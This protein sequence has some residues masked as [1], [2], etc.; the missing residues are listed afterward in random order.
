MRA[1]AATAH[2]LAMQQPVT[3][4]IDGGKTTIASAPASGLIVSSQRTFPRALPPVCMAAVAD[5]T[6][7]QVRHLLKR[8][9]AALPLA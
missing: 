2:A 9:N 8:V 3:G 1:Q 7:D 6:L 4:G 5:V